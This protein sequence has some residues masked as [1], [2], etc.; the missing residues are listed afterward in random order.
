MFDRHLYEKNLNGK[1]QCAI[2]S[3]IADSFN[4]L[5]LHIFVERLLV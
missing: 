3:L 4:N 2:H 1:G 5:Y